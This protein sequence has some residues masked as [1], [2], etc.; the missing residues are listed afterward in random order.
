MITRNINL[1]TAAQESSRKL[2]GNPAPYTILIAEREK[3]SEE[4]CDVLEFSFLTDLKKY[5]KNSQEKMR[6]NY[7]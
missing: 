4:E 2:V 6:F 5:R 3:Y 7:S 1:K